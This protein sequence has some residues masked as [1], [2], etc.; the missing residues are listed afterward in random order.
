[1]EAA[2]GQLLFGARRRPAA[3]P[4]RLQLRER[5][6]ERRGRQREDARVAR[7]GVALRGEAE[8]V[9]PGVPQ[10]VRTQEEE[11]TRLAEAGGGKQRMVA[12]RRGV[13]RSPWTSRPWGSSASRW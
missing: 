4:P 1:M 6:V 13:G 12:R 7:R 3:P 11:A 8:P 2:E 5:R 9:E 10:P